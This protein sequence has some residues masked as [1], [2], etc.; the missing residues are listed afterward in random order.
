MQRK[1][2]KNT[3]RSSLVPPGASA[4]GEVPATAVVAPPREARHCRASLGG[5]PRRPP[6]PCRA[7]LPRCSL[8]GGAR[9]RAAPHLHAASLPRS[10]PDGGSACRDLE[11]RK[12]DLEESK[13]ERRQERETAREKRRGKGE[14]RH[15]HVGP[16]RRP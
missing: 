1:K 10:S 4:Q 12:G 7:S 11:E 2:R 15:N 6:P 3:R 8:R 16:R 9:R 13:G 5:S 14:G